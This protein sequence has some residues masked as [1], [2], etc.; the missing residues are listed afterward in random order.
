[1]PAV[2]QTQLQTILMLGHIYVEQATTEM[3][4]LRLLDCGLDDEQLPTCSASLNALQEYKLRVMIRYHR[5]SIIAMQVRFQAS[6]INGDLRPV[7]VRNQDVG[8]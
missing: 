6:E 1:M 3:A 7:V 2:Q 8:S 5:A 4:Q